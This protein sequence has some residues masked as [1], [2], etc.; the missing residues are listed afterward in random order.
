MSGPVSAGIGEAE[1]IGLMSVPPSWSA[2]PVTLTGATA[3][4]SE[5]VVPA[6]TNGPGPLFPGAPLTG[7]GRPSTF[8]RRR[9]GRRFRVMSRPPAAG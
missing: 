5:T 1:K 7:G 8:A 2:A 6:A 3:E 4:V 9:Y